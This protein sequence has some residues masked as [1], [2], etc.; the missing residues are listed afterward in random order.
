M[1]HYISLAF[2]TY[3]VRRDQTEEIRT[4]LLRMTSAYIDEPGKSTEGTHRHSYQNIKNIE[5]TCVHWTEVTIKIFL[6][7]RKPSS[8]RE[9]ALIANICYSAI[10]RDYKFIVQ[11]AGRSRKTSCFTHAIYDPLLSQVCHYALRG[12]PTGSCEFDLIYNRIASRI[13]ETGYDFQPNYKSRL[14]KVI[15]V[16]NNVSDPAL[17]LNCSTFS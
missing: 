15:T 7:T 9:K 16:F 17:H 1:L 11:L 6:E 4:K 3:S 8:R 12:N 2:P 5:D 10:T 14:S 13:L